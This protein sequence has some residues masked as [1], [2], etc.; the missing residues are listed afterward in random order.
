M[1]NKEEWDDWFS[2][3]QG[4]QFISLLNQMR[5]YESLASC[6]S[7]EV[8]LAKDGFLKGISCILDTISNLKKEGG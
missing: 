4:K 3:P 7:Y 8:Y 5:D 2:Q 6:C 1:F